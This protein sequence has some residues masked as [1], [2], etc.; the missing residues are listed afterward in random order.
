MW[1]MSHVE[2]TKFDD[3][4][5]TQK[6]WLPHPSPHAWLLWNRFWDQPNIFNPTDEKFGFPGDPSSGDSGDTGICVT[7]RV[8][9]KGKASRSGLLAL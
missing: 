7:V 3:E 2:Y 4:P 5:R 6:N 8:K 9:K 1:S